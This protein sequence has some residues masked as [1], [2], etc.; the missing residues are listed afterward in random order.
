VAQGLLDEGYSVRVVDDLSSGNVDNVP[1]SADLAIGDA[2]DP[3]VADV[4]VTR[5]RCALS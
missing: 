3:S 1:L 2:A 4:A 5:S